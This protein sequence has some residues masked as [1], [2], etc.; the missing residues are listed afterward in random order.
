MSSSSFIGFYCIISLDTT[1]CPWI[2]RLI[3]KSLVCRTQPTTVG[4]KDLVHNPSSKANT[5]TK[6]EIQVN[7]SF[8]HYRLP[9][10]SGRKPSTSL[11]LRS[12]INIS[13]ST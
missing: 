9:G 4:P 5:K 8:C 2:E 7:Y 13:L 1:F 11:R 12:E 3:S 6:A 10:E